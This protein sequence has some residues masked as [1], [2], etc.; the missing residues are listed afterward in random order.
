MLF[1]KT[2]ASHLQC[3][4]LTHGILGNYRDAT[5]YSLRN[6]HTIPDTVPQKRPNGTSN[7]TNTS[8]PPRQPIMMESTRPMTD[9]GIAA[10]PATLCLKTRYRRTMCSQGSRG[11]IQRYPVVLG[12]QGKPSVGLTSVALRPSM[13][14]AS[15]MIFKCPRLNK[16]P[17]PVSAGDD[18]NSASK[19]S[20]LP[21]G[22]I[23]RSIGR[24][25]DEGT[26]ST[27]SDICR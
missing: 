25:E 16:C 20:E 5:V 21:C 18:G 14:E 27:S 24:P 11:A 26:V 3:T 6:Y 4:S 15:P 13:K 9:Q 12:E 1:E 2:K 17:P 19:F 22:S 10:T 23:H 7:S 8:C